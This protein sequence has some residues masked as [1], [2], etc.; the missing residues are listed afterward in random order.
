MSVAMAFVLGAVL[1]GQ[2]APPGA[3]APPA[4]TLVTGRVVDD[5]TGSPV[6]NTRVTTT[7]NGVGVPV[8][9]ADEY[10]RFSLPVPA[11]R[12][13]IVATKTG[14]QKH[15]TLAM[16]GAPV[17]IRLERSA[18]I[19]GRV[20]DEFGDPIVGVPVT[21]APFDSVSAERP[22]I[23]RTE[24]ND[25]GEYR[26][27]GL[28][29]GAFA[30]SI[31]WLALPSAVPA[32]GGFWRP[33]AKSQSIYY[34]GASVAKDAQ[35]LTLGPGDE[36]VGI[37]FVAAGNTDIPAPANGVSDTGSQVGGTAVV[38]GKVADPG[39]RPIVHAEV[40]LVSTQSGRPT[41]IRT[42][43]SET[44][45][46]F[47]LRGL[48][49]GQVSIVA[50]RAGY[51][52][53]RPAS[54]PAPMTSFLMAGG[55]RRDDIELH[56]APWA[57]LEGR[58]VDERG[59]PVAEAAVQLL[60]PRYEN[61]ERSL[62]PANISALLTDDRGHYRIYAIP[63]GQ[64]IVSATVADVSTGEL[65]GYGRGYFPG[66][67]DPAMAQYISIVPGSDVVGIE[68]PLTRLRTA[69][70]S[71]TLLNPQGEPT[72]GGSVQLIP[73]GSAVAVSD[74]ARI[75][76]RDGSFEFVNV[77]PG[78]YVIQVSRGR[79][80]TN[81]WTEGD[82]AAMRVD[83]DG[84]D[85]SGLVIRAGVGSA[86]TGRILL[87]TDTPDK[88]PAATPNRIR[89]L[90]VPVDPLFAPSNG[91]ARARINDDWTFEL[92]GLTGTRRLQLVAAP[93]GWALEAVRVNDLDVTDQPLAF[94]GPEGSLWNVEVVLTDRFGTVT[95]T[96]TDERGRPVAATVIVY[97]TDP[98]KRYPSSRFTRRTGAG[99]SGTFSLRGLPA[100]Q[101]YAAAVLRV[102]SD[103]AD[104]W[105]D[106]Q[107]LD[108][109]SIRASATSI[110]NGSTTT[111]RLPI[112]TPTR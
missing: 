43:H 106:L 25:R 26:V 31:D 48:P 101:Y 103:G 66:V 80:N 23:P 53:S 18:A 27:G 21:V 50:S 12:G 77:T 74:G 5:K 76:E 10:G 13:G 69:R 70:I 36:R 7:A 88:E 75:I 82:F 73:T 15:Q 51:F 30:V 38:R 68:V 55:E 19:S 105:Q 20:T 84:E 81:S 32:G 110:S 56:L 92:A 89:L 109:L 6:P 65:P 62:V 40:R 96:V 90:P 46:R 97:S 9:L 64:Y 59:D 79:S 60:L 47:E 16:G 72:S 83:V 3:T 98:D 35:P 111:I 33:S 44:D 1:S 87:N 29:A 61:G 94:G 102:P 45:G 57:S 28:S 41:L 78:Q 108:A 54:G 22:A 42:T 63:P 37:D 34:P 58:V 100:G 104:A 2:S 107:Y 93:P 95:G 39:G 99:T 71:G 24:T 17:E 14:Y 112:S 52:P 4:S 91:V 8:V 67:S 86:V 85:I 11:E 49:G